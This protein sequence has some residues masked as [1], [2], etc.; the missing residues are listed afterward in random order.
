VKWS[1]NTANTTLYVQRSCV[2]DSIRTRFDDGVK[3][4]IDPVDPGQISL[5]QVFAVEVVIAEPWTMSGNDMLLRAG[6][7]RNCLLLGNT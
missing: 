4:V 6:V 3:L 1:A 5:D 7:S 2:F